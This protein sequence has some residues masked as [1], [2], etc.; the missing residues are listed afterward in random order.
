[1]GTN[2]SFFSFKMGTDDDISAPSQD[3]IESAR[4]LYHSIRGALPEAV[5]DFESKWTAWQ[6]VCQGQTSW[7]RYSPLVPLHSRRHL[8]PLNSLDACTRTDEFEALKRLGPKILPFV[9][10]KLA[11][12]ADHNSYGVFLC[13]PSRSLLLIVSH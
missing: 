4:A 13:A 10:F 8:L 12:N 3:A 2:F 5:T 6:E 1:M 9:V 11:T 7:P